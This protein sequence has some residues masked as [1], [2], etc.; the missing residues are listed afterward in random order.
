[1][2]N[3]RHTGSKC[4]VRSS[5][6]GFYPARPCLEVKK[7]RLEPLLSLEVEEHGDGD[8]EHYDKADLVPPPPVVFGNVLEVH[9]VYPGNE[10]KWNEDGTDN[11]EELH[12]LVHPVGEARQVDVEEPGEDIPIGLHRVNRLEGMI[13]DIAQVDGH[14]LRDQRRL[15]PLER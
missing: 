8:G 9:S 3:F 6:S 15:A 10:R 11:S 4:R 1:M 5:T 2:R 12:D 13:V 7:G 14:R